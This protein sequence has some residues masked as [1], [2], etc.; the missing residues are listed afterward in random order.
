MHIQDA[1]LLI[2]KETWNPLAGKEMEPDDSILSQTQ[3]DECCMF[4]CIVES[5]LNWNKEYLK[6]E[7]KRGK[8]HRRRVDGH[9]QCVYILVWEYYS[10]CHLFVQLICFNNDNKKESTHVDT[11]RTKEKVNKWEKLRLMR[12]YPTI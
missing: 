1:V 10:E 2:Y 7:D 9:D 4:P 3:K 6:V 8:G 11:K 5:K 12:Q